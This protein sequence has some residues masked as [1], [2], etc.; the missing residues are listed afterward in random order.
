MLWPPRL[1]KLQVKANTPFSLLYSNHCWP[2]LTT[3][4]FPD[5]TQG[6]VPEFFIVLPLRDR[7]ELPRFC[8]MDLT[9][10]L[11]WIASITSSLFWEFEIPHHQTYCLTHSSLL[12][13]CTS[14]LLH[15]MPCQSE[16]SLSCKLWG[17][18]NI[19]KLLET[20]SKSNRIK[21]T[22]L[23]HSIYRNLRWIV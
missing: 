2:D 19:L 23:F 11:I 1:A 14:I 15:V 4:I 13:K 3:I 20:L 8:N 5:P 16:F 6:S 7:R 21:L 22:F 9:L 12:S 17:S 18:H 10:A